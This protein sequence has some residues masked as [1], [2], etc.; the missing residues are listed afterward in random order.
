MVWGLE[1]YGRALEAEKAVCASTT[2]HILARVYVLVKG[3]ET[4]VVD[5]VEGNA[6]FEQLALVVA[7]VEHEISRDARVGEL[8]CPSGK[9][10]LGSEGFVDLASVAPTLCNS[11]KTCVI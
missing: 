2:V 3:V 8:N 7:D 6:F 4:V 9:V 5:G 10:A 11:G 1:G